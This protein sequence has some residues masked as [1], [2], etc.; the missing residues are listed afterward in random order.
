MGLE[1]GPICTLL[2]NT[3]DMRQQ[4][5]DALQFVSS[6]QHTA[7]TDSPVTTSV[8]HEGL[9]ETVHAEQDAAFTAGRDGDAESTT[10]PTMSDK[11]EPPATMGAA[12][13]TVCI[14][15]STGRII[16]IFR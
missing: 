5:E 11:L 1:Y 6:E 13:E 10:V 3:Q 4:L 9:H 15:R 7:P 12:P 2:P 14:W 16:L 8:A